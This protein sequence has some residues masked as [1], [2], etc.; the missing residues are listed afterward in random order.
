MEIALYRLEG[1]ISFSPLINGEVADEASFAKLTDVQRDTFHKQAE[2]LENLV[3][4]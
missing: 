4:Y 1:T 3:K 2:E